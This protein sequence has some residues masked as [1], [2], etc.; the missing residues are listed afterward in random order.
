MRATVMQQRKGVIG[1][2]GQQDGI[3]T[4]RHTDIVARIGHLT[5]M[6]DIEPRTAKNALLLKGEHR[7]I[8]I[9]VT[10]HSVVLYQ[11]SGIGSGHEQMRH[12]RCA[13]GPF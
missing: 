13:N 3:G 2:A 4:Q 7:R 1:L 8:D 6:A 12:G 10:M 9:G 11:V 5:L